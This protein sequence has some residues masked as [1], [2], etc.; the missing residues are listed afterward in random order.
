M[1]DL[2][3][4]PLRFLISQRKIV[5]STH[6]TSKVKPLNRFDQFD[7]HSWVRIPLG[8][9]FKMPLHVCFFF[10]KNLQKPSI[11][12]L[13][14]K[15]KKI[16]FNFEKEVHYILLPKNNNEEIHQNF[17]ILNKIVFGGNCY[18]WNLGVETST[19][20]EKNTTILSNR[21]KILQKRNKHSDYHIMIKF[22]LHYNNSIV[23]GK[24]II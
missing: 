3:F 19:R 11:L 4:K 18:A 24:N 10:F 6:Q 22:L 8:L 15:S 14:Q 20:I 13:I 7:C 9:F 16:N 5:S 21:S 23:S 12:E 2:V 1:T 17:N